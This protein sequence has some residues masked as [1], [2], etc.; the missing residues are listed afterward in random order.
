MGSV[1]VGARFT[2]TRNGIFYNSFD[3][4]QIDSYPTM[5]K[6]SFTYC[7]DLDT[8]WGDL[9]GRA[10]MVK[11]QFPQ[12]P[13]SKAMVHL[14]TVD[15]RSYCYKLYLTWLLVISE[16]NRFQ[17]IRCCLTLVRLLTLPKTLFVNWCGSTKIFR[18]HFKMCCSSKDTLSI[19]TKSCVR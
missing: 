12:R 9:L 10:L 8:F 7:D 1:L 6:N 17:F 13:I 18:S 11:W 2:E 15:R 3:A 14:W 4:T 5:R 16:A 19:L